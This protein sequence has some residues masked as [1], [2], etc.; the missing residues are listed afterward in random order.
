MDRVIERF[1]IKNN[2]DLDKMRLI[3]EW[4]LM[5]IKDINLLADKYGIYKEK[6][7]IVVS[8]GD[9]IGYDYTYNGGTRDLVYN[10]ESFFQENGDG[11]HTRAN[12]ML[13]Y[14]SDNV[15]E[16]LDYSFVDEAMVLNEIDGSY[17]VSTNGLHRFH[18]LRMLY[19]NDV[20]RIDS[21]EEKQKIRDKYV[22]KVKSSSL[23]YV[24][25]YCNFILSKLD[26]RCWVSNEYDASY[27]KTGKTR[28]EVGDERFIMTDEEL[29]QFTLTKFRE[30]NLGANDLEYLNYM[31]QDA[32]DKIPSFNEFMNNYFVEF[33]KGREL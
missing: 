25:T 11:Y 21:E 15:L 13:D 9:I 19:L 4:E 8:L 32:C 3:P 10:M 12:G 23:D 29:V 18:V 1:I 22:I 5:S 20:S 31:I 16:K 14:T 24:K 33:M 17:F 27:N 26:L 28:V 2:M 6:K 7:D 30:T